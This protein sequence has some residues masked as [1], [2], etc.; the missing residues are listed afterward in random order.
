M[1]KYYLVTDATA[2]QVTRRTGLDA[3]QTRLGALVEKPRPFNLD[4]EL[5]RLDRAMHPNKPRCNC[6][7]WS[8]MHRPDCPI[9]MISCT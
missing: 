7:L 3:H 9:G 1:K 5:D 6:G 8:I 4:A 2:D